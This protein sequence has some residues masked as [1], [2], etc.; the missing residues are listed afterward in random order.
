MSQWILKLHECESKEVSQSGQDG[1]L[2][3]IFKNIGTT[4]KYFV[5]FGQSSPTL[6]CSNTGNLFNKGWKGLMMDGTHENPD[7]NLHKEF[8]TSENIVSLFD[9]YNVPLE[10][11]YVSIDIDSCDLWVMRS[12]L[13]SKYKPRVVTCEYNST[14]GLYESVTML[15]IPEYRYR[16][17]TVFGASLAA[18]CKL[19]KESGYTLVH[20]V[21]RL[22]TFFIRNDLIKGTPVPPLEFFANKTCIMPHPHPQNMNFYNLF[23][24]Y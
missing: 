7:I 15:D 17:D 16:G 12:I 8:I 9:K 5:E 2:E 4:N 23:H 22:D 1:I 19:A 18:L 20:V 11:D 21:E 14:F 10:P 6:E 24:K 3:E 13:S